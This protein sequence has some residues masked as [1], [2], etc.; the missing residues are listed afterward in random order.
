MEA[1]A[2]VHLPI[3]ESKRKLPQKV[4]HRNEPAGKLEYWLAAAV[5][6]RGDLRAGHLADA[7]PNLLTPSECSCKHSPTGRKRLIEP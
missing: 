7:G 5:N 2:L 6:Q 3:T 4:D 1:R